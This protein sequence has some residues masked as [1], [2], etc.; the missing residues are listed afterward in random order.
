MTEADLKWYVKCTFE[1]RGYPSLPRPANKLERA[2]AA[3]RCWK[4]AKLDRR[5]P[6]WLPEP[7]DVESGTSPGLKQQPC[8]LVGWAGA[9]LACVTM[10]INWYLARFVRIILTPAQA[11]RDFASSMEP[12][13]HRG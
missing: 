10:R 8:W 3:L 11:R 13:H 7:G 5:L 2:T 4:K 9:V 6:V 12:Q 1:Q